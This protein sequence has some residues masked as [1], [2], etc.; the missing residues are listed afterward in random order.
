MLTTQTPALKPPAIFSLSKFTPPVGINN[1]SGNK[2]LKALI[3]SV[4]KIFPEK[5]L[6]MSHPSY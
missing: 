1:N 3:N 5:S 6:I 2:G 4:P